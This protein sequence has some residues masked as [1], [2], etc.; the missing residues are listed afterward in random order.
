MIKCDG[1]KYYKITRRGM[2]CTKMRKFGATYCAMDSISRHCE[3]M[4]PRSVI[5][6]VKIIKKNGK[7]II[8][9]GDDDEIKLR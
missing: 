4:K 9:I 5:R 8:K 7:T 2:I 3:E 6:K 1:C